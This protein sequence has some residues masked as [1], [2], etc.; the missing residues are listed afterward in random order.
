M[1]LTSVSNS[2]AEFGNTLVPIPGILE[3]DEEP[4]VIRRVHSN[5]AVLSTKTKPKKVLF[6]GSDGK[7]YTFLLKGME[8]LHLD[9]RI[10]QLLGALNSIFDARKSKFILFIA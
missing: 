2:L 10:G 9:E 6:E 5:L 7:D 1:E 8:D 3:C 4:V